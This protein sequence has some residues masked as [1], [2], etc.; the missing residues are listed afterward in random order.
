MTR[1]LRLTAIGVVAALA[2]TACG[3]S[4]PSSGGGPTPSPTATPSP[5]GS[6]TEAAEPTLGF[7]Q[8]LDRTDDGDVAVVVRTARILTGDEAVAAARE[9]GAIGADEQLDTDYWISTAAGSVASWTVAETASVRVLEG[10]SP[11]LRTVTLDDWVNDPNHLSD[12]GAD[13]LYAFALRDGT[14]TGIEAQYLP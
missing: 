13:Q 9:E 12:A 4:T 10:G 3:G 7:V 1:T 6:P 14:V 8:R 11:D 5:A 2:L